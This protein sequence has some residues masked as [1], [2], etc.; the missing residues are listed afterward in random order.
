MFL[1]T[2]K[3]ELYFYDKSK[4]YINYTFRYWFFHVLYNL[5]KD[6]YFISAIKEW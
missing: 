6:I 5:F 2:H 4:K 1:I 3:L